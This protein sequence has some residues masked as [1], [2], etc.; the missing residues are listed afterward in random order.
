MA[1]QK[2]KLFFVFFF[3]FQPDKKILPRVSQR[4]SHR[5]SPHQSPS[6]RCLTSNS[7][8]SQAGQLERESE[9]VFPG[10][11]EAYSFLKAR[12]GD[13]SAMELQR[14]CLDDDIQRVKSLVTSKIVD[15]EASILP[16][17]KKIIEI[18][19]FEVYF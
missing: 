12:Y 8:S 7:P 13:R 11:H 16:P 4:S 9:L 17:V 2:H 1:L 3:L 18:I 14:A 5:R 15:V 6:L 10:S 19:F